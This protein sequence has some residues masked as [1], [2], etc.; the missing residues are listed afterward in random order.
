M[1]VIAFIGLSIG[2]FLG[3]RVAIRYASRSLTDFDHREAPRSMRYLDDG[4]YDDHPDRLGLPQ[5]AEY[6]DRGY[7]SGTGCFGGGGSEIPLV[8]EE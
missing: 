5:R 2:V 6:D 3:L 8:E 7:R 4:S 1:E